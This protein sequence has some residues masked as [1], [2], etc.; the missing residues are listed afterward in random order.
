MHMDVQRDT[1]SRYGAA[2][3]AEEIGEIYRL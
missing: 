1:A 2:D 3:I